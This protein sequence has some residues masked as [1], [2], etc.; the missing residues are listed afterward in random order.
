M[1]TNENQHYVPRFYLKLFSNS[2][3][4]KQIGIYNL[5]S[6][7][8]FP[9]AKLKTQASKPYYYGIDLTM[10]KELAEFENISA[11]YFKDII[12]TQTTP[13][14][15]TYLHRHLL[16]LINLFEV[17]NPSSAKLFENAI[18][19]T[20]KL[21]PPFSDALKYG[22][23]SSKTPANY[24]IANIDRNVAFCKDLE[25]KLI[26]NET[27]VP[28]ITSDN[29]YAKYNQYLER[30]DNPG[31]FGFASKGFQIFFPLNPKYCIVIYDYITYKIGNKKDR[32]ITVKSNED[33]NQ[34]NLLQVAN[35]YSTIFFNEKTKKDYV[36]KLIDINNKLP[37]SSNLLV[38][39]ILN[40]EERFGIRK[41]KET[42]KIIMQQNIMNKINLKLS[43]IK[44][45]SAA[46]SQSIRKMNDIYRKRIIEKQNNGVL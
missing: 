17:R 45:T 5:N 22:R 44:L 40:P 3:N 1:S 25:I 23:I 15:N 26:I 6:D 8:Y 41:K 14:R 2:E 7:F 18:N 30:S 31:A 28:F 42:N 36:L 12:N 39:E 4:G 24:L 46:K 20:L 11:I 21:V 29:P 34:L 13:Q 43:F 32:V 16:F 38:E 10:E 35:S 37:K 9:N 27:A 33:I 19:E